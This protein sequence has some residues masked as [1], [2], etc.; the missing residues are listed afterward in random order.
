MGEPIDVAF[1][2]TEL[3][4]DDAARERVRYALRAPG[5]EPDA[6]APTASRRR[7]RRNVALGGALIAVMVVVAVVAVGFT[8][9]GTDGRREDAA[10]LDPRPCSPPRS[11]W[12]PQAIVPDRAPWTTSEGCTV[13][14]SVIS[15]ETVGQACGW[16]DVRII[17]VD[18]S[19]GASVDATGTLTYLYDP[20]GEVPGERAPWLHYLEP[21]TD[22]IDTGLYHGGEH[23]YVSPNTDEAIYV[24]DDG[25]MSRWPIVPHVVSCE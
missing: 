2:R 15:S 20:H 17:S 5:A 22:V 1:R 24:V 12:A 14:A 21:R 13:P 16:D 6:L 19:V 11:R 3:W 25:V 7:L 23:V 8:G 18:A 10:S 4:L 9:N